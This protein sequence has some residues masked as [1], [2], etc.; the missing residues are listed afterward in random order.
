ML[1]GQDR[2]GKTNL[3]TSLQGFRFNPKEGSIVGINVDPS[4]FKGTTEIWKAGKEDQAANKEEI[5]TSFEHSVA[6]VFVE[7]VREQ[8]LTSEVKTG[9]KSKDPLQY[10]QIPEL[11]PTVNHSQVGSSADSFSTTQIEI[12]ENYAACANLSGV[13][14][15]DGGSRVVQTAE[16]YETETNA[17]VNVSSEM[18]PKEIETFIRE[19]GVDKME[20][21][22]YLYSVLWNFAGESVYYETHQLFLTSRAVYLLIYDLSRDPEEIAQPVEK[23]GVF[24]KIKEKSCTKTNVDNLDYQMTSVSSQ[25]SRIEAHDLH[26][27]STCTVLPKTL[28]PVFLVCTHSEKPFGGKDPFELAIKL[29][30]S[31][32]KK[33]YSTQLYDK[34]F[35]VDN[36]KSGLQMECSEEQ[37]L[38][39][40]ILD[41][42]REL[43]HTNEYIPIKWLR[44]EKLLK[45]VVDEEHKRITF[46]DALR[47]V[48]EV[49]QIH[50][51]QE[52]KTVFDFL[53]DQR[54]IMHFDDTVELNKLVVLD[55]Q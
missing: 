10:P 48:S 40:C 49:C 21:E 41:V 52:F 54:I 22:D 36:T 30:G 46:D 26:S 39:K 31:L 15:A 14:Y 17:K 27:A 29:Y 25:S 5:A 50:D 1:I 55:P 2:S 28:P 16:N 23:Q 35:V 38:R 3:K 44:Y 43:P 42:I 13:A 4:H 19:L 11:F 45:V 7:N 24:E 20:S 53:H 33:S 32:E 51:H 8:E 37:R 18:I 9:C 6:G 34:V 12:E 47:I